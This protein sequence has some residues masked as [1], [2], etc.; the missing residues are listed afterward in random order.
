MG[1][2]LWLPTNNDDIYVH[3]SRGL[4]GSMDPGIFE[5]NVEMKDIFLVSNRMWLV[6]YHDNQSVAVAVS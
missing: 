5:D 1:T 6:V 2:A 4:L 3:M